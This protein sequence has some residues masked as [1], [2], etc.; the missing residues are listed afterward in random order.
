[1]ADLKTKRTRKSVTKFLSNVENAGRR[2]D[3]RKVLALMEEITGAKPEMW[4]ES[5]IG[6]GR[7]RYR[8]A[9]G[10]EGEWFLTGFSPQKANI[11][12]YIMS[13]FSRYQE[14]LEK[15]GKHK[16]GKACLYINRLEDID[17]KVLHRL[18]KASVAHVKRIEKAQSV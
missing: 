11:T 17:M 13:G 6:F 15:L 9:S 16:T 8:Y 7:Y 18:V 5:L 12:L 14:L 3:A 1:M 4:G 2:E 10:R